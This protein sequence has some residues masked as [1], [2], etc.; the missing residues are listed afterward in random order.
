MQ[1]QHNIS[2]IALFSSY[3]YK[4]IMGK[5]DSDVCLYVG[6]VCGKLGMHNWLICVSLFSQFTCWLWVS[7]Q[8]SF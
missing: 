4:Y 3:I 6:H 7:G 2:C 8:L 1:V 5:R